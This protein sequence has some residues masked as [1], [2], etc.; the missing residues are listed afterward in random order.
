MLAENETLQSYIAKE[1]TNILPI[2]PNND[3]AIEY[4]GIN[5]GRP[6]FRLKSA[7]SVVGEIYFEQQGSLLYLYATIQAYRE[8]VEEIPLDIV[9]LKIF[10]EFHPTEQTTLKLPFEIITISQGEDSNILMDIKVKLKI[11]DSENHKAPLFRNFMSSGE[12]TAKILIEY[13]VD[14]ASPLPLLTTSAAIDKLAVLGTPF[15]FNSAQL[16]V[17]GNKIMLPGGVQ[18]LLFPN[19]IS[20]KQALKTIQHF[21]LDTRYRFSSGIGDM[22]FDLYLSKGSAPIIDTIFPLLNSNDKKQGGYS[23]ANFKIEKLNELAKPKFGYMT[24]PTFFDTTA[25]QNQLSQ[26]K[27]ILT[28]A[29]V[30]HV[31]HWGGSS[32]LQGHAPL[33]NNAPFQLFGR[34]VNDDNILISVNKEISLNVHPKDTYV[35]NS[36]FIGLEPEYKWD[37]EILSKGGEE[38]T[39]N[40]RRSSSQDEYY[41][42]PQTYRLKVNDNGLPEVRIF[43]FEQTVEQSEYKVAIECTVKSYTHPNAKRD[44]LEK[45]R[46]NGIKYIE[47]IAFGGYGQAIFKPLLSVDI[48]NSIDIYADEVL[49]K[50]GV[51][52]TEIGA[53]EFRLK[54]VTDIE[55]FDL[56]RKTIFE[57]GGKVGNVVFELQDETKDGLVNRLSEPLDVEINLNKPA[58]IHLPLSI[59]NI[60]NGKIIKPDKFTLTNNYPYPLTVKGFGFTLLEKKDGGISEV[61]LDLSANGTFP[62]P[63]SN[64][65]GSNTVQFTINPNSF[66]PNKK[67]TH[68]D[69]EPYSIYYDVDAKLIMSKFIDLTST[70][71]VGWKLEVEFSGNWTDD[72]H[73]IVVQ[74]A[75]LEENITG[76]VKLKEEDRIGNVEMAT[77]LD[78]L[79]DTSKGFNKEYKYRRGYH[80]TSGDPIEEDWKESTETQAE[81]L[82]FNDIPTR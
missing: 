77:T 22:D 53:D 31:L 16:V 65:A 4:N 81:N 23:D 28:M 50:D 62:A 32:E 19:A 79:L 70:E 12:D 52:Q 66:N 29:N 14:W 43:L 7:K 59:T 76:S 61:D 3:D 57:D 39:I 26:L 2:A 51:T 30:N 27:E 35:F 33:I 24:F 25:N 74:F 71:E 15:N 20:A 37:K 49:I 36:F 41:F 54:F 75:D 80:F 13:K 82:L 34:V 40:Y 68:F 63:I 73:S 56:I 72:L 6:L 17:S 21:Q 47:N 10:L 60:K 69:V 44:L 67:W 8:N 78:R 55:G 48:L 18:F 45:L 1:I 38:F 42:L 46:D 64:E 5:Y 11:P 9:D 58:N